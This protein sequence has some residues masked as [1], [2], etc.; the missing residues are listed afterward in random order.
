MEIKFEKFPK[1]SIYY[2]PP[3]R[4]ILLFSAKGHNSEA[5][6]SNIGKK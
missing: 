3:Q 1:D 6:V 2:N 5:I 4:I